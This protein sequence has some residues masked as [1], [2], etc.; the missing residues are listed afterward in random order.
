MSEFD[1]NDPGDTPTEAAENLHAVFK[2]VVNEAMNN[3][4]RLIYQSIG[5]IPDRLDSVSAPYIKHI[6]LL[7]KTFYNKDSSIPST[8]QVRLKESRSH[9]CD[10]GWVTEYFIA[11]S[12]W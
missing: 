3:P 7:L 8:V 9:D 2:D 4:K 11:A 5:I 10:L 6:G 12:K 1:I